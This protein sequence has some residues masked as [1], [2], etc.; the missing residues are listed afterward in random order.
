MV[1]IPKES[2]NQQLPP[3][4]NRPGCITPEEYLERERNAE[5]KS[6][7]HDGVIV[8]MAGASKEHNR[9]SDDIN[10]EI[11]VQI[12]GEP[13]EKFSESM[14]VFVPECNKYFYPD[15]AVVCGGA[16]FQTIREL[17][18]LTNQR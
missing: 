15:I 1:A 9:I 12:K 8:A 6:E 17:E 16:H 14:R 11:Y 10:G 5:T 7:Y 18:S 4:Q 2:P 3:S 13:C